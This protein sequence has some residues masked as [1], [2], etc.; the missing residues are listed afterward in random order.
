MEN[1][2]PA[3]DFNKMHPMKFLEQFKDHKLCKRKCQLEKDALELCI[4]YY[5]D[6]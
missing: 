3:E 4:E 5:N 2:K 6:Q 1:N